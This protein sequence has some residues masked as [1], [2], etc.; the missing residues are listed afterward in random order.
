MGKCFWG[1]LSQ[2]ERRCTGSTMVTFFALLAHKITS[3]IR[4]NLFLCN[5]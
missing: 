5:P 4:S 2:V 3:S 1:V